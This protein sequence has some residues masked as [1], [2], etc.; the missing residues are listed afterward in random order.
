VA[1]LG[2]AACNST[3]PLTKAR[4]S[5]EALATAVLD[6]LARSD[7]VTLETLALNEQEFRDH[8]WPHLPVARPERN[9]PFSYIWGDLRQK[10]RNGLS[11]TLRQH[12]GARYELRQVTFQGKTNY[13][14]YTVHRDAMLHVR[15]AEGQERELHVCGSMIEEGGRWKVFSYVVD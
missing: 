15:D 12:G 3:P 1:L 8:V 5:P 7:R 10:S 14:P 6:A 13:G 4:Q 9:M 2:A 11:L